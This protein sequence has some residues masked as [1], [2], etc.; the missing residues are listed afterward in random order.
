MIK[1]G[2][3]CIFFYTVIFLCCVSV[4]AQSRNVMF[5][6]VCQGL[7]SHNVTSGD[8]TQ[9]KRSSAVKRE[10]KSSGEY[11]F[12]NRGIV[13]NTKRPFSSILAVTDSL[14]IQTL[15]DGTSSVI[16]GS[17]NQVFA[18]IAGTLSSLFSGN[19]DSLERNFNVKFLSTSSSWKMI[20]SPKDSTIASALQSI[21]LTGTSVSQ[22][23]TSLDSMLIEEVS[24]D[25][26]YYAFR[27]QTYKEELSDA[28]KAFFTAK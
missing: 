10:L 26:V 11:I 9:V 3:F 21:V 12:S 24:G 20:L 19:R 25:S 15:P 8:F 1:K 17:D 13:W 16:N 27:N 23:Q 6:S 4:S 18:N 5:D 22:L 28:E 2:Y 14:I 7:M